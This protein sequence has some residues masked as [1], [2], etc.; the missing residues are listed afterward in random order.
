[1]ISQERPEHK[2]LKKKGEV[3]T[4]I[5]TGSAEKDRNDE[6]DKQFRGCFDKEVSRGRPGVIGKETR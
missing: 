1:V 5:E 6:N 3:A 4:S 2:D